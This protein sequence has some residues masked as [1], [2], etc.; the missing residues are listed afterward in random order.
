MMATPWASAPRGNATAAAATAMAMAASVMKTVRRKG[1]TPQREP[2]MSLALHERCAQS[3]IDEARGQR[4]QQGPR[5]GGRRK[6][7]DL[8]PEPFGGVAVRETFAYAARCVGD[9]VGGGG[10]HVEHLGGAQGL[11]AL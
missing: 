3:T 8:V 7:G 1:G 4:L 11:A 6:C 9:L 5:R 10:Q 2:S